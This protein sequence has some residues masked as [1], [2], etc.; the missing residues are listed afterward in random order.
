MG[1]LVFLPQ[2]PLVQYRSAIS[3]TSCA[4][5]IISSMFRRGL[6]LERKSIS[7]TTVALSYYYIISAWY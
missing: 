3:P 1:R 2:S 7:Y 4:D 6:T 5:M